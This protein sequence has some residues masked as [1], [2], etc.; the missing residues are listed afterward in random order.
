MK[1]VLC[2]RLYYKFIICIWK[3]S[4][5]IKYD[6]YK[7]TSKQKIASKSLYMKTDILYEKPILKFYTF[8]LLNIVS[9]ITLFSFYQNIV[10]QTLLC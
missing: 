6:Y 7:G 10:R 4:V 1:A 8:D 5:I 9:L 2:L 3:Q